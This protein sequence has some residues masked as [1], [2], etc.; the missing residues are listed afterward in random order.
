VI[1]TTEILEE[2]NTPA[3]TPRTIASARTSPIQR[4][5]SEST[6]VRFTDSPLPGGVAAEMRDVPPM[7]GWHDNRAAIGK[8]FGESDR[9]T[10]SEVTQPARSNQGSCKG[11]RFG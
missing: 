10:P 5:E 4:R 2:P 1:A 8:N 3:L 11:C 6:H 9:A 7:G